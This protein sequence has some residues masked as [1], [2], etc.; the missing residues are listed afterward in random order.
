[1]WT[2]LTSWSTQK[3]EK[4]NSPAKNST[5]FRHKLQSARRWLNVTTNSP[6][7]FSPPPSCV[8]FWTLTL[9]F[10][11]KRQVTNRSVKRQR[12]NGKKRRGALPP[13]L[14]RCHGNLKPVGQSAT[15]RRVGRSHLRRSSARFTCFSRD[16]QSEK[17][18]TTNTCVSEHVECESVNFTVDYAFRSWR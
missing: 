6:I 17:N 13:S 15:S 10:L 3:L 9:F 18:Q 14:A 12:L 1:M 5:E 7:Y 16:F 2:W 11:E 8:I 4:T